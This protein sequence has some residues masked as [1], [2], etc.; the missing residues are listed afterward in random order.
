MNW[1]LTSSLTFN[2]ESLK[3]GPNLYTMSRPPAHS[4]G[5]F[6]PEAKREKPKQ[7]RQNYLSTSK[8][9]ANNCL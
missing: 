1:V 4:G 6:S 2:S 9:P 8:E 7:M 3:P 5:T